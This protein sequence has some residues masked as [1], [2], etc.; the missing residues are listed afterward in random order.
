MPSFGNRGKATAAA[1]EVELVGQKHVC[2]G[3][4]S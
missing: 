4:I 2:R 1:F 3:T